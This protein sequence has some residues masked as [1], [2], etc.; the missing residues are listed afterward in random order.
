MNSDYVL[1]SRWSVPLS[2][3]NLWDV[4]DELLATDDP[5]VWWP[6]V[7][8]TAYDGDTMT[9]RASSAFGYALTFSLADLT[10]RRPDS[11]TFTSV[12]DLRGS[13]DVTFADLGPRGCAMTI[14]W[15]VATD[16]R[17]M[18]VTGW[19]LRP[20]F[21]AGHH[22]I[23]RQGEKHLRAYLEKRDR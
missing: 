18:Q 5:M 1:V 2:R 23:M 15:R 21:V 11:L 4:L 6:S 14:D 16:R 8:V 12:G 22:L 10:A 17:W 13:G 19:V 20:V 3:E 7:Q 9:V